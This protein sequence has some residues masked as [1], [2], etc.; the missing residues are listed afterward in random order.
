MTTPERPSA[1]LSWAELGCHDGTPYP[2]VY[3]DRALV[4]AREF[5]VVRDRC[6]QQPIVILSGYR[7]P[8]WNRKVGGAR[9]SQHVEGR[10]LDLRPPS[11]LTVA[12]F[13]VLI[14]AW[15]RDGLSQIRGVGR[16]DR[17]GFVHIDIRPSVRLVRWD[18]GKVRSGDLA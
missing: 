11:G 9:Q 13:H 6:G 10:A 5:E 3:T 7:T 15:A 16:Y 18:G 4:L 8:A 2:A 17:Q 14:L 1:H 12:A